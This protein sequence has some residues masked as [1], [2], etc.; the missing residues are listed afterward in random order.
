VEAFIQ[1]TLDNAVSIAEESQFVPLT[2][3]QVAE[4]QAAF[5][6]AKVGGGGGAGT[7]TE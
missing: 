7:E 6:E 4:Q 3:E 2:D 1:Y 5:E